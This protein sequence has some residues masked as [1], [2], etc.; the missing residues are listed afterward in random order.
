[1]EPPPSFE[2]LEGMVLHL[3][4]AVYST[5]QGGCIWYE[6]IKVKLTSI[7]YQ[8]T[9]VDHTVFTHSHHGTVSIIT[10]YV[11][12]ITI[13]SE[14]LDE[15]SSV[16]SMLRQHYEITD[17]GDIAWILGMHTTHD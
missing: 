1:M 11:D 2:I 15:I 10:L 5:H 16:K 8:H 6:D 14:S 9:E 17:L 13:A 3:T 7:G 12:N 4:K